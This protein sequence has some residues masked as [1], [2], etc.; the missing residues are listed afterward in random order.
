MLDKLVAN[1]NSSYH[2]GIR[3]I[4]N[5]PDAEKLEALKQAKY[6]K[7]IPEETHF[8]VGDRVRFQKNKNVFDKATAQWSTAIHTVKSKTDH[9][10][11]NDNDHV[12]KSYELMPV[13]VAARLPEHATRLKTSVATREQLK[14]RTH[15]FAC[16]P[17]KV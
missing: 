13:V 15:G 8:E 5:K 17:E 14:T 10:Y 11:T 3:G 12:Y 6:G 16:L 2:S 7:A 9:T 1:Y 4:P